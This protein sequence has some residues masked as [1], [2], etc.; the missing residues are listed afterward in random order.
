MKANLILH[1]KQKTFAIYLRGSLKED[2]FYRNI[3]DAIYGEIAF[4]CVSCMK[5]Y[6]LLS[7]IEEHYRLI[8][9]SYDAGFENI[10]FYN[11]KKYG[12]EIMYEQNTFVF[13]FQ[14]ASF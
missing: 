3:A 10:Q 5:P 12:T 1:N 14:P 7:N 6:N 2:V 13:A 4:Y 8:I 9:L 11:N